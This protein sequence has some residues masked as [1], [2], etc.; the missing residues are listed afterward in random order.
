MRLLGSLILSCLVPATAF[1][2]AGVTVV[3]DEPTSREVARAPSS[4]TAATVATAIDQSA[5]TPHA[6]AD[7]GQLRTAR[8]AAP[9]PV[10]VRSDPAVAR[11]HEVARPH[12]VDAAATNNDMMAELAAHQLS[13]EAKR[14]QRAIDGCLG[15]AHKRAP[16]AAGS[17]TL[18]FDVAER[19][20]KSVVVTSDGVHDAQLAACLTAAARGFTFSLASARFRWPVALR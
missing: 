4:P 7:V 2:D 5:A 17:L 8:V 9:A 15:A 10:A 13:K 12:T 11:E 1:A 20:V 3:D 16:A 19:K 14:H 6:P 18:D